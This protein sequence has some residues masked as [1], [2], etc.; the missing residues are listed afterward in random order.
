MAPKGKRIKHAKQQPCI[1]GSGGKFYPMLKKVGEALGKFIDVPGSFWNDCP[2]KDKDKIYKCLVAEYVAVHDFG[3][4]FK[5][6]G[7]KVRAVLRQF[8]SHACDRL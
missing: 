3:G 4:A 5:S 2:R 8:L 1:V 6:G 7:F